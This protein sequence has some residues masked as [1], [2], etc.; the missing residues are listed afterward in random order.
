MTGNF[1]TKF[2]IGEIMNN[3]SSELASTKVVKSMC[4]QSNTFK[5]IVDE[6]K[7]LHNKVSRGFYHLKQ[8]KLALKNKIQQQVTLFKKDPNAWIE[9]MLKI[10]LGIKKITHL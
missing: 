10:D 7:D 4:A 6:F 9:N 5:K 1:A 8:E 3:T 2:P